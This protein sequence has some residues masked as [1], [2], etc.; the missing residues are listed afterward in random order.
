MTMSSISRNEYLYEIQKQYRGADKVQRGRLLAAAQVVTGLNRKYLITRLRSGRLL[1]EFT[2]AT[3]KRETRGR[4]PIYTTAFHDA[5][6]TCW[7][8]ENDICAERL[9]PFLP[10]LVPKL[11]RCAVLVVS[12]DVRSLL[13]RASRATSLGISAML[14]SAVPFRLAPPKARQPTQEPDS[15]PERPLGRN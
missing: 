6:L 8:A 1:V 7:H 5:L 4:K 3:A 13:L 11:E 2:Q 9:Q 10:E 12:S 14:R 15:R